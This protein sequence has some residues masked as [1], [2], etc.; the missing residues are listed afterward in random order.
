ML[1]LRHHLSTVEPRA[2]NPDTPGRHPS[3]RDE[4]EV[5]GRHSASG[6]RVDVPTHL[7]REPA[8]ASGAPSRYVLWPFVQTR[9][10]RFSVIE[11]AVWK[12]APISRVK[13][14]TYTFS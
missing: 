7:R 13:R 8:Q 6:Q 5:P 4:K 11:V 3:A 12:M 9:N 1:T 14:G 2:C 10:S